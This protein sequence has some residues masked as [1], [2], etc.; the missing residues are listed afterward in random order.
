MDILGSHLNDDR[1][2]HSAAQCPPA[3]ASDASKSP[4]SGG[5]CY[6]L[7]NKLLGLEDPLLKSSTAEMA[8]RLPLAEMAEQIVFGRNLVRHGAMCSL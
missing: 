4:K 7:R 6:E 8:G 2:N 5:G 3:D 1:V